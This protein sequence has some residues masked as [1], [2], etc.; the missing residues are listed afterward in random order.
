MSKEAKTARGKVKFYSEQRRFGFIQQD[1]KG[2]DL[3]FHYSEVEGN[4]NLQQDD[5]VEFEVAEGDRGLKAI[6]VRRVTEKEEKEEVVVVEEEE[7]EKKKKKK[8]KKEKKE[9]K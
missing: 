6:K 3:F 8:K 7:E 5:R 4:E 2:E 1:D 9:E